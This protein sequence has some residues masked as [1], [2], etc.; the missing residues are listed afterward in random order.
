VE[1]SLPRWITGRRTPD[2]VRVSAASQICT[3]TTR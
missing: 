2:L 1:P 3:A